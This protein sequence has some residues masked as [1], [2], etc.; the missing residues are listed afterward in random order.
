[1]KNTEAPLTT[2]T[3]VMDT[4]P[5]VVRSLAT[6]RDDGRLVFSVPTPPDCTYSAESVETLKDYFTQLFM[7]TVLRAFSVSVYCELECKRHGLYNAAAD[8]ILASSSEGFRE[9]MGEKFSEFID[10]VE[11]ARGHIDFSSSSVDYADDVLSMVVR[12][13]LMHW[14][15]FGSI[16]DA[17]AA[18]ESH[19]I[20]PTVLRYL[21]SSES[22]PAGSK[23][24]SSLDFNAMRKCSG[25]IPQVVR[26]LAMLSHS[27]LEMLDGSKKSSSYEFSQSVVSGVGDIMAAGEL[28]MSARAAYGLIVPYVEQDD[29]IGKMLESV[30][31]CF[32]VVK[33]R[34]V[35]HQNWANDERADDVSRIFMRLSTV[36]LATNSSNKF[37]Q[38]PYY[39]SNNTKKKNHV[40]TFYL[41]AL[42]RLDDKVPYHK[43]L[44]TMD[45]ALA[46][47]ADSN[48]HTEFLRVMR[49]VVEYFNH[50]E[51]YKNEKD[52]NDFIVD[53]IVSKRR[54]FSPVSGSIV[55]GFSHVQT[56]YEAGVVLHHA[57]NFSVP[58]IDDD[59]AWDIVSALSEMGFNACKIQTPH[60]PYTASNFDMKSHNNSPAMSPRMARELSEFPL[61]FAIVM[62]SSMKTQDNELSATLSKFNSFHALLS[63][64]DNPNSPFHL[65]FANL[66]DPHIIN[67]EKTVPLSLS[68]VA[69]K[70]LDSKNYDIQGFES[71]LEE[72]DVLSAC[73]S[74]GFFSV[75]D[76]ASRTEAGVPKDTQNDL[77]YFLSNEKT[78]DDCSAEHTK[79]NIAIMYQNGKPCFVSDA[80]KNVRGQN[81]F[82]DI[83]QESDVACL[84][85]FLTRRALHFEN[86]KDFEPSLM[87]YET[88]MLVALST[89]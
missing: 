9:E 60:V 1:M 35:T 76:D 75:V 33:D 19:A 22:A 27:P 38:G 63:G 15:R 17:E 40:L 87:P 46:G 4:Y 81:K 89:M 65:D 58:V 88:T 6:V 84:G 26:M 53:N 8:A 34:F 51:L 83:E 71:A 39:P 44:S 30:N 61:S 86:Q 7:D 55:T 56:P 25:K 23:H 29:S 69:E 57:L 48:D 54:P 13:I 59:N 85:V 68:Q 73:S 31:N 32:K 28:F 82:L 11:E 14:V 24:Q 50:I 66:F 20:S 80:Y 37:V 3:P 72:L 79:D 43:A 67:Q 10:C 78:S 45:T 47:A 70:I 12:I 36:A 5:C 18:C 49:Y 64:V 41:P 52:C 2:S 74:Y 16:V 21:P 77:L 62:I 42:E